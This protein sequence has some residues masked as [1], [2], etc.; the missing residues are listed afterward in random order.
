MER[1]DRTLSSSWRPGRTN[2]IARKI[3]EEAAAEAPRR[4]WWWWRAGWLPS[5]ARF[6][7]ICSFFLV[8]LFGSKRRAVVSVVA[9]VRRERFYRNPNWVRGCRKGPR[10]S[11][12]L[13]VRY[14]RNLRW[15]G[16]EV[17]CWNKEV[18]CDLREARRT[19]EWA[20]SVHGRPCLFLPS[21]HASKIMSGTRWGKDLP[22]RLRL[23]AS[24]L[25]KKRT[26]AKFPRHAKHSSI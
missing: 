16:I 10:S 15:I 3:G 25:K 20:R 9:G 5:V 13:W 4:R 1:P 7:S 18:S 22:L 14:V 2:R 21:C 17:A 6:V 26:L 23:S 8:S 11:K 19:G 12:A 24:S